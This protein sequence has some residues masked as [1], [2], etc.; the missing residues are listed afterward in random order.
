MNASRTH[1][2][3]LGAVL[4]ALPAA[5]GFA[6]GGFDVG[7]REYDENCASCHGL[8]GKGDGAYTEMLT[9]KVPDLTVLSRNN[10]GVFPVL[11]VYEVIDGRAEVKSHGPR[12]MPIWGAD[13]LIAAAPSADDYPYDPEVMVRAR[14]L[15]LAEYLYRLQT[16]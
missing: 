2:V 11:R 15:A 1:A 7:K 3:L 5:G 16:K 10:G 12:A 9:T 13:Y 8:A 4:L 6:A 14:I